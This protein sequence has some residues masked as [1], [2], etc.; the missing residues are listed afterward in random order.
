MIGHIAKFAA[1]LP[2]YGGASGDGSVY[3][4]SFEV[5]PRV[6]LVVRATMPP[7]E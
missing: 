6:L 3:V 7:L 1:R 4:G 2:S 5:V